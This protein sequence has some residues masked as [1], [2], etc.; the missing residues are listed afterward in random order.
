MRPKELDDLKRFRKLEVKTKKNVLDLFSGEWASV[1]KGSGIEPEDLRPYAFQ[2]PIR[3]IDWHVTAKT[4]KPYIRLFKEERQLTVLLLVDTSGS[5]F[6]GKKREKLAEMASLIA[7]CA[8]KNGDR[9][10]LLFFSSILEKYIPPKT[11][12]THI[13]PLIQELLYF[14]PKN[15]G[16]HIK[17][18]LEAVT[19]LQ[20]KHCALFIFS[21]F[22]FEAPDSLI[23]TLSKK[24]D[25]VA[26]DLNDP[27]ETKMDEIEWIRLQDM[28]KGKEILINPSSSAFQKLYTSNT[29]SQRLRTCKAVEKSGGTFISLSTEDSATDKLIEF[30]AKRKRR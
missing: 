22:L 2:D 30:F 11:G 12:S 16:T 4:G 20:K 27:L 3:F 18:A 26:I 29:K 7:F 15:K 6:F 10:G 25:L 23:S 8:L 9:V 28:E 13:L 1:Y 19:R 17:A 5:I 24:Y 21:D 14:Q